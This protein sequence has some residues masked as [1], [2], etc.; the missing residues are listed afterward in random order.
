MPQIQRQTRQT[1][2][3]AA[4]VDWFQIL[5]QQA[6]L[7]S[8]HVPAHYLV[9]AWHRPHRQLAVI[10]LKI[11]PRR[12][13][14][15]TFHR[16]ACTAFPATVPH[17]HQTTPWRIQQEPIFFCVPILAKKVDYKVCRVYGE[18]CQS[19]GGSGRRSWQGNSQRRR[20]AAKKAGQN[21]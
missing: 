19:S 16:R 7:Q 9:A 12:T 8:Q 17:N 2:S 11:A 3:D 1:E 20:A 15:Q 18:T 14:R 21:A 13:I 6:T 5:A 4:E 10:V